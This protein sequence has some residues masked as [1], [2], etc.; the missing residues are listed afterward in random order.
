MILVHMVWVAR[1]QYP[2]FRRRST[3]RHH[4]AGCAAE[5]VQGKSRL[6]KGPSLLPAPLIIYIPPVPPLI[7]YR[8][9]RLHSPGRRTTSHA[10]CNDMTLEVA[11][12][13]RIP[14]PPPPPLIPPPPG[15]SSNTG[16]GGD[17]SPGRRTTSRALSLVVL[18]P[19]L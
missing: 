14:P 2:P 9:E 5:P 10:L 1:S 7:Q 13:T 18:L 19:A 8:G 6:S 16:G 11:S 12:C 17:Y 3:A 15:S 4:L